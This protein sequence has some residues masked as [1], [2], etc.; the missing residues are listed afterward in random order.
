MLEYLGAES[1]R[2]LEIVRVR[3]SAHASASGALTATLDDSRDLVERYGFQ[4]NAGAASSPLV[5]QQERLEVGA[6]L[7]SV[8]VAFPRRGLAGAQQFQGITRARTPC[9]S[10]TRSRAHAPTRGHSSR[11]TG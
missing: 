8:V 7:G 1:P 10:A 4:P 9:S 2:R 6:I 11:A 5:Q 3:G